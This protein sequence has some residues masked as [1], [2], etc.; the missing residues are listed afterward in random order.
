MLQCRKVS[1]GK[2]YSEVI[3]FFKI[4]G[5]S[6]YFINLCI[7]IFLD[8]LCV[9]NKMSLAVP[10]L[11]L[12][13]VLPYTGKSSLELR[14]HFRR[15]IEKNIPFCKLNVVFRSTCRLF[16]MLRSKDFLEKKNPLWNSLTL[17][18]QQL[19]GYLLRENFSKFFYQSV[20]TRKNFESNV[21]T[22]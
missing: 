3:Q 15:M 9:K 16:H 18:V 17:Y 6:K 2:Q 5:Y 1:S 19:Q 7:K 12:M 14:A 11:Q 20:S 10:K 22:F 4:N 21:K 8:K 13:C